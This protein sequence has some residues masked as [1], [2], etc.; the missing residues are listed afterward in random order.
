MQVL[1]DPVAIETKRKLAVNG[2]DQLQTYTGL[3][4]T[5]QDWQVSLKGPFAD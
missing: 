2:L 1:T 5:A 3:K 4:K